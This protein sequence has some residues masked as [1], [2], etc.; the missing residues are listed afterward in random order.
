MPCCRVFKNECDHVSERATAR[1]LRGARFIGCRYK[2][3]LDLSNLLPDEIDHKTRAWR[4]MPSRWIDRAERNTGKGKA[5]ECANQP[6]A[7]EVIGHFDQ[8]E[9][10]DAV[11]GPSG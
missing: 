5:A 2:L 7:A 6:A 8:S 11:S 10:G 4:E 9:I 1:H 3:R